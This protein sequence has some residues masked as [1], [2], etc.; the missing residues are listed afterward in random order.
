[1]KTCHSRKTFLLQ[2]HYLKVYLN[3]AKDYIEKNA[4]FLKKI[5]WSDET[6]IELFGHNDVPHVWRKAGEVHLLKNI[7]PAVNHG[8][9]V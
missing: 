2:F 7:V 8:V 9:V 6:K 3:F 1:M 5:L 4:E